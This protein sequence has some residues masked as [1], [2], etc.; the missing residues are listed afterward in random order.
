MEPYFIADSK[1]NEYKRLE[2]FVCMLNKLGSTLKFAIEDIAFG[3]D[4][5][6]WTTIIAHKDEYRIL[7]ICLCDWYDIIH[8]NTSLEEVLA[9][10]DGH[11]HELPEIYFN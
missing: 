10:V 5:T 9:K 3:D 1:S 6:F 7:P 4:K 11:M 8:P 2:K